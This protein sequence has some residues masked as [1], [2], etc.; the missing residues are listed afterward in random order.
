MLPAVAL[1]GA[2]AVPPGQSFRNR[3]PSL[4]LF[5]VRLHF[6]YFRSSP[7]NRTKPNQH[8]KPVSLAIMD[9]SFQKLGA[10]MAGLFCYVL[11][12]SASYFLSCSAD[13]VSLEYRVG[14]RLKRRTKASVAIAKHPMIKGCFSRPKT[15]YL[16][17]LCQ[18]T[19]SA[20]S[21]P[22]KVTSKA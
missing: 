20:H 10:Q 9:K 13:K 17:A 5:G 4:L 7:G 12:P 22:Q 19:E 1:L 15:F 6:R 18:V 8:V 14:G 21:G 2:G 3:Q 16:C 11:L